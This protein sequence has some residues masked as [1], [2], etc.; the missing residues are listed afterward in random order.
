MVRNKEEIMNSLKAVLGDNTGDDVLTLLEDIDDTLS[1]SND[2]DDWKGK[3]EQSNEEWRTKY[4]EMD[5]N[6]RKKYVDRFY[7]DVD[8]TE[9]KI[10]ED[11]FEAEKEVKPTKFDDLFT[12][13]K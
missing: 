9:D 7:G 12:E 8:D 13:E 11:V 4:E 2:P 1:V 6:W 5:S 10:F 3:Y